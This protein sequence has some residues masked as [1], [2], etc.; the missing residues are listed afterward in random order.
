MTVIDL[1][2]AA[3]LQTADVDQII[4]KWKTSY[5]VSFPVDTC[6]V[7][8]LTEAGTVLIQLQSWLVSNCVD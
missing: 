3:D 8:V 7:S 5:K 6:V 2:F 1:G 4:E